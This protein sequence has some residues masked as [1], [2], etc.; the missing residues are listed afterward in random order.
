ML[1]STLIYFND[2]SYWKLTVFVDLIKLYR[3]Q[4]MDPDAEPKQF[5]NKFQSDIRYNF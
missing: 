5:L 3:S 1:F 4:H 2:K